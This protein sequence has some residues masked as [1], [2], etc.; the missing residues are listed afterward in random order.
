MAARLLHRE[1]AGRSCRYWKRAKLTYC[2]QL[3]S[4]TCLWAVVV[5]F[6]LPDAPS[7]AGFLTDR[8]RLIAVKRVAGNETGIK[9][10]AFKKQQAI[11]ALYD[12]KMIILFI[13]VFAAAI[14]SA[15]LLA[16]STVIIRDLGFSSTQTTELKSVGDA[17]QIVSLLIAGLITFNIPNSRLLTSTA[18][19]LLCAIA[20]ALMVYLP[21]ENTWGRLVCFWLCNA[22]SVGFTVS[23][24]T[25]SSNMAGYT[26]RSI[27]SAMILWV[28]RDLPSPFFPNSQP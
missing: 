4:V 12:P 22:Q 14:P 5:Y 26:H 17:T 1:S 8:E 3:G 6:A 27:A 15:V 13:S 10:K 28:A 25:I 2:N 20:A 16:F 19:N 21:R 18:A 11:L 9:N 23:V 24:I 7:N